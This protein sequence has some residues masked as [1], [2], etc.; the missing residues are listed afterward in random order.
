MESAS[1]DIEFR[2]IQIIKYEFLYANI[3]HF[4]QIIGIHNKRS[5]FSPT[6]SAD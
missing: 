4:E 6:T 5:V 1:E 2:G 3:F